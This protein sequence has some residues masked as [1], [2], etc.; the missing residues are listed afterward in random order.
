MRQYVDACKIVKG[1][2]SKFGYFVTKAAEAPQ[3]EQVAQPATEEIKPEKAKKE[4]VFVR[5]NWGE[6]INLLKGLKI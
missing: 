5:K 4:P 2:E 1:L 6:V 3:V